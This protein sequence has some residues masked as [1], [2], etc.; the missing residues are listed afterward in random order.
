[1]KSQP[2][3]WGVLLGLVGFGIGLLALYFAYQ[4]LAKV[5]LIGI[6]TPDSFDAR[7]ARRKLSVLESARAESRTGFIRLSEA[8]V[9]SHLS[10]HYDLVTAKGNSSDDR[11][12]VPGQW[13]VL[14]ARVDLRGENFSFYTWLAFPVASRRI[15]VA[16]ERIG[17]VVRDGESWRAEFEFMKV[18]RQNIPK[19]LM[20][21]VANVFSESDE[22]FKKD[23]EFL[24]KVPALELIL[25]DFT[26]RSEM[27]IYTYAD[28]NVIAKAIPA[29]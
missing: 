7:E 19:W 27:R 22:A 25:N 13:N 4:V 6:E 17:R 14:K 18:G 10:T 3:R 21:R 11:K 24:A 2:K 26:R 29:R 9:N 16:F 5:E 28:T 23:R 12:M 15:E 1:M 20:P 8:E